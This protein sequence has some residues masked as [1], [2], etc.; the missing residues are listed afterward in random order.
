MSHASNYMVIPL[1]AVPMQDQ[2]AASGV[3][4]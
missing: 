2:I 3:E 4:T 1:N